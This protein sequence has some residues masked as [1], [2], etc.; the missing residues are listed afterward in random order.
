MSENGHLKTKE[1]KVPVIAMVIVLEDMKPMKV[2]F[3]FLADK[4]ATYGFL[5]LAEKTL[6]DYYKYQET[7]LVQPI[8]RF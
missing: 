7:K 1:A 5:K 2:T 4:I 8:K 3:P 6:D